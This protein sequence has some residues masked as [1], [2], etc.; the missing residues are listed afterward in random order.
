M[1]PPE[2]EGP[3]VG[4][5]QEPKPTS[6]FVQVNFPGSAVIT[7]N[8]EGHD[9]RVVLLFGYDIREEQDLPILTPFPLGETESHQEINNFITQ[10]LKPELAEINKVDK[11]DLRFPSLYEMGPYLDPYMRH[12]IG[13]SM[14]SLSQEKGGASGS[15]KKLRAALRN[16]GNIFLMST[17]V[18]WHINSDEDLYLEAIYDEYFEPMWGS[19]PTEPKDQRVKDM[20]L[21]L[22]AMKNR[23]ASNIRMTQDWPDIADLGHG[24][25]YMMKTTAERGGKFE[26]VA[27]GG[28]IPED[29]GTPIGASYMALH[30]K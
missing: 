17:G 8:M 28:G 18:H 9:Y 11:K 25:P 2:L 19:A 12:E 22:R 30:I 29:Y 14:L 3:P 5:D 1:Y 6:Y 20:D 26:I 27:V 16:M 23:G 21:W 15:P 10:L 24:L 4:I 7:K 13:Y